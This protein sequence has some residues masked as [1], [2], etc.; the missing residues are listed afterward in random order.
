MILRDDFL[1]GI[2]VVGSREKANR[3]RVE[4]GLTI[5]NINIIIKNAIARG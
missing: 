4:Y 5:L 3:G 2:K 1:G